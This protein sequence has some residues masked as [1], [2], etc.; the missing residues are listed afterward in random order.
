M[1]TPRPRPSSAQ[2]GHALLIVMVSL[3]ICTIG[4]IASV[5]WA[6]YNLA[7]TSTL[8]SHKSFQYAAIAGLDHALYLLADDEFDLEDLLVSIADEADGCIEG[9]ISE[10]PTAVHTPIV[11]EVNGRITGQYSVDICRLS[12]APGIPGEQ[13]NPSDSGQE[14]ITVSFDLLATGY[15][16][17]SLAKASIGSVVVGTL[18]AEGCGF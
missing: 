16:D 17:G 2:S 1:H 3:S 4:A 8:H 15:K 14:T 11:L 9:W 7:Q 10:E 18:Q 12:C 13:L 6:N 5:E